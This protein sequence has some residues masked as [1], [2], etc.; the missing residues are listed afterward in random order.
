MKFVN[1]L[2]VLLAATILLFIYGLI[3]RVP[4]IDDAWLGEHAY[5]LAKLGYVKS[6]LMRGITY[7]H[8]R[9]LCHHKLLTL[10]GALIVNLFGFSLYGLKALS[11]VYLVLFI[12]IFY[13][14]TYKKILSPPQF[15]GA[16]IILL[17][18]RPFYEFAFVFR[19]ELPVMTIGFLSYILLEKALKEENKQALVAG[20]G[21]LAGVCVAT[22]LN[23]VIFPMAG[24]VLLV[25]N[26]RYQQAILFGMAAVP[27]IA[28]YFFD[29]TS[30]Y[31][32]RF[33]L[34][35]LNET[36]SHDRA[37]K[38]PYGLSYLLNLVTEHKRYFHSIREATFYGLFLLVFI[39]TQAYLKPFKN[40]SRYAF[41]LTICLGL[42]AIHKATK[43]AIIILPYLIMLLVLGMGYLFKEKDSED[44]AFNKKFLPKLRLFLAVAFV[45]YFGVHAYFD[46]ELANQKYKPEEF[47]KL[48]KAYL[49]E[50]TK[51]LKIVAPMTFIY[52]NI[53]GFKAIQ[54]DMCYGELN[55]V[56]S[57]IYQEEFLNL[58]KANKAD[59][60]ILT[61]HYIDKFGL[62]H[63]TNHD[64][65]K[66]GFQQLL[67]GK[68][69]IIL[70]R[71]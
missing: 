7:Q 64:F 33:W 35:Q 67:G 38:L 26:K 2:K 28:V 65:L 68:E 43:Y 39:L 19:P 15:Y 48:V 20:S 32:W 66:A 27:A 9:F 52:G 46:F 34:Y 69:L 70:K 61:D 56:N 36:P 63:Y 25:W 47:N 53:D 10:Q 1:Y 21:F 14:Y 13:W 12:L 55:R 60:L 23:G 5:W 71:I 24:F 58:T 54:A 30:G 45:F 49:P 44:F 17:I 57:K 59:Y 37:N 29:F 50:D 3:E 11:L 40:L 31:N 4:D 8:I 6:E 16:L 18:Y 41:L 22:H 51:N 62:V 42:L